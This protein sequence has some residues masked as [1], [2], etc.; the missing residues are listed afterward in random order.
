MRV[1]TKATFQT[2]RLASF[3][4]TRAAVRVQ[5]YLLAS[6]QRGSRLPNLK[7]PPEVWVKTGHDWTA[8]SDRCGGVEVA[9]RGRADC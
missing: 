7:L 5:M 8:C 3:G 4:G 2:D 9:V 6:I 1:E